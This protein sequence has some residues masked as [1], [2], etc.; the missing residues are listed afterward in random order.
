MDRLF[1]EWI[2]QVELHMSDYGQ[3][4][5][6]EGIDVGAQSSDI[7]NDGGMGVQSSDNESNNEYDGGAGSQSS[8]DDDELYLKFVQHFRKGT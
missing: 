3:S 7:D 5:D 6:D 8:D 2:A 4:S 1:F